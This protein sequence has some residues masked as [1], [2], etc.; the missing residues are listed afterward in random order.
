MLKRWQ[1][2]MAEES[3]TQL[4]LAEAIRTACINAARDGYQNAAISGLCGEG[5]QESALSAMQMLDL[6]KIMLS[7][8]ESSSR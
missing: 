6:E 8:K 2:G 3:R 1:R 4:I 5:A 7:L